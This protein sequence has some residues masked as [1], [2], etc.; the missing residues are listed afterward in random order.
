MDTSGQSWERWVE[1]FEAIAVQHEVDHLD[2]KL[3]LDR[4]A[5]VRTDLFQRKRYWFPGEQVR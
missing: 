5:N 1:G 3:F 4:I 2:G